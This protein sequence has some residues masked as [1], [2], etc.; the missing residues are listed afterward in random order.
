MHPFQAIPS[1]ADCTSKNYI[2]EELGALN[3]PESFAVAEIAVRLPLQI[4]NLNAYPQA[5]IRL[6]SKAIIYAMEKWFGSRNSG[7]PS[8]PPQQ[9]W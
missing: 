5:H 8:S 3:P 7:F 4:D 2:E 1:P 9:K 6:I